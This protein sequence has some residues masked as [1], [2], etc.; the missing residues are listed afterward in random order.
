MSVAK[1]RDLGIVQTSP[2]PMDRRRTL[3]RATAVMVQRGKER[4]GSPIEGAL[5]KQLGPEDEDQVSEALAALDVLARLLTPEVT[6]E[7]AI[8]EDHEDNPSNASPR[9]ATAAAQ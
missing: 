1:L 8:T 5:A 6:A 2:D 7:G 4:G 9:R 3:V